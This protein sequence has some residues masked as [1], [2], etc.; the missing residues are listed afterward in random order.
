[1]KP[2]ILLIG[3]NGQ[4][5]RALNA[6]LPRVG[7]VSALDRDQ[8]DLTRT[9]EIRH[10]VR[11]HRPA[12]IVIAAAYTA[13]DQAESDEALAQAVNADAPRVIAEEAKQIGA[14]L[15]H[16][17]T[18]YVFDGAKRSPYLETDAPSPQ[19]AYGRTKLAGEQAI[20]ESG[21]PH[22]IFR[23]AWVFAREGH[24]FLLTVLRLA[25]QREVLRIVD[26]QVG[27]PTWSWE[28]AEATTQ[29]LEQI[30]ARADPLGSF[31]DVS[32]V[33]H[34]TAA[35]ETSWYGFA[36]AILDEAQRR[37]PAEGWFGTAT[38]NQPLIANR[39]EPITTREYPT[40]ARRPPYS[41]LS[42]ALLGRTFG[43]QLPDW[44]AQLHA[45]FEERR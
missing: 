13:V 32:G 1:M 33:Y 42:N 10:A 9:D 2:E 18:D 11:S 12:I 30:C 34:M 40:P 14:A 29:V 16:F 31:A 35:G 36:S 23:T 39:V 37:A 27:A 43:I 6:L 22:L 19:S 45:V 38:A 26:D 25:T 5:G 41:V 24:N 44:R 20:R 3:K 7:N 28:I 17:S 15:V 21:V 8:L 4:V